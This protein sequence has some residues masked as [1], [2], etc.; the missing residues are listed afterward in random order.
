MGVFPED[1]VICVSWLIQLWIAEG[2]LKPVNGKSFEAV[3]E[4]YLKEL[5]AR[6]IIVVH[7]RGSSGNIKSCKI[8]DL[9][10]DLCLREAQKEKFFCVTRE[11][12][13]STSQAINTQRRIVVRPS[14]WNE[15]Y[16]AHEIPEPT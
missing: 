13:H 3:A 14:T 16:L 1:S 15:E 11:H 12:S 5:I 6:N 4:D 8:H 9:L 7:K 2:F 10:R